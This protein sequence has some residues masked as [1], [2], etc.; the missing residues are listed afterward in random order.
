MTLKE[1][2]QFDDNGVC[3]ALVC[4]SDEKCGSRDENGNPV[5]GLRDK[6]GKAE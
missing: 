6:G 5:Y 4:Y 2:C 3:R 1:K